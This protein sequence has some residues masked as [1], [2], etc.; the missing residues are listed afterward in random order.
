M[1]HPVE[2]AHKS[3]AS[4]VQT[5]THALLLELHGIPAGATEHELEAKVRALGQLLSQ[6]LREKNDMYR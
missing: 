2:I 1:G 4:V 5:D 6:V 3:V